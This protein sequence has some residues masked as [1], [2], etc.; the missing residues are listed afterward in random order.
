MSVTWPFWLHGVK[1][2]IS[3]DHEGLKARLYLFGQAARKKVFTSVPWQRCLFHMQQNA[4]HYAPRMSMHK[5]LAEV[6][7]RIYNA[8]D[9]H[10]A[11]E[12][13]RH[14][15]DHFQD[16]APEFTRWLEENIED[17]LTFFQ[18]PSIHH[19]RIR[20]VNGVEKLNQEIARRTRVARLF[21][22]VESCLIL[23]TVVLADINDDWV[24]G[25]MYLS[26]EDVEPENPDSRIYRKDV[27]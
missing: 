20:T 23:V 17:G 11:R 21:P 26:K 25:R 9:I 12:M 16:K 24:A 8:C 27:A 15:V 4:Q 18:F 1:R 22:N 2:I 7:R 19:R 5:E 6:I 10:M 13:V 14:A 3:D